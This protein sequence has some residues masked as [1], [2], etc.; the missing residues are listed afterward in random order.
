M[1]S[2]DI[3]LGQI[4]T[5]LAGEPR[6]ELPPM[7]E[8]WPNTGPSV[9]AMAERFAI[10]LKTVAGEIHRVP[11]MDDA[12]RKLAE[13]LEELQCTRLGAIDRPICRELTEGLPP[14]HLA[15][16]EPGDT[17][18]MMADLGAG[19]VPADYL[20]ADTGSCLAVCGTPQERLMCY[21]PP[22]CIVIARTE[23]LV[24][25]LPAAWQ[26][27]AS[28]AA[29]P[30]LRGEFV[31]ITGPSRTADIEK[32]LILGVHGPKRLVVVLVG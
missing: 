11:T 24:E 14:D 4:R 15:W 18:R 25:H 29:N 5:A 31:I 16:P 7:C 12:R 30:N 28:R 21:L 3:I 8:V 26:E 13:L 23:Q 10:E 19:V 2:R 27:V 20:L 32:I 1:T 9:D 17:A 22:A 6:V